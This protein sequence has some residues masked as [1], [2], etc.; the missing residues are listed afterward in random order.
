M[1]SAGAAMAPAATIKVMTYN[2]HKAVGA[3]V[4]YST[5]AAQACARIVNYYEPDVLIINELEGSSTTG[6]TNSLKLWCSN[7]LPYLGTITDSKIYVSPISDGYIRNAIVSKYPIINR[8][9]YPMPPR[10]LL[11]GTIDIP[12]DPN[13]RV[14]G[15]HF[16]AGTSC[17]TRQSNAAFTRDTI[18]DWSYSLSNADIPY[19]ACGDFN[20]DETNPICTITSSYH[21]ISTV[22][23]AYLSDYTPTDGYGSAKTWSSSSPSVRFDYILPSWHLK[24][25]PTQNP[26][27]KDNSIICRTT[28]WFTRGVLPPGLY[29]YDCIDASDHLAVLGTFDILDTT[30]KAIRSAANG[31]LVFVTKGYVTA[32]YSDHF[33]IEDFDR[34][35]AIRVNSN[36]NPGVNAIVNVR[37]YMNIS[38][39]AEDAIE[40]LNVRVLSTTQGVIKPL[41]MSNKSIN[42]E[43][44]NGVKV[45][46]YTGPFNGALLVRIWGR[47]ESP[48]SGF[49][50]VNDGSGYRVRIQ[51]SKSVFDVELCFRYW[52]CWILCIWRSASEIR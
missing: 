1:F 10:D 38:A 41:G 16:K 6:A 46:G 17:T 50:Y 15:A 29:R 14:F 51:S 22:L 47:V 21:P 8:I 12:G 23:E 13:V 48:G 25:R 26:S 36:R 20:E 9:S 5:E 4:G 45:A 32:S 37:G 27:V 34:R 40:A 24:A 35:A 28:T 31:D 19:L 52:R 18:L 39:S 33:Y 43:D 49:F 42:G 7:Y 3:N 30:V 11:V 44:F 2:I